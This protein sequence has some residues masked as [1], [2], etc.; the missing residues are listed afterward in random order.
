[1]NIYRHKFVATCPNNG[2]IIFYEIEIQS[3]SLIQAEH[4]TTQAALCRAEPT[5]HER[6]ADSFFER[7]GGQQIIKAN[8]H[9]VEIETRRGFE[10]GSR[11]TALERERIASDFSGSFPR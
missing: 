4:I 3:S 9:G 10:Q 8:H 6:I 11:L 5:Y 1:M 2:D 7:F